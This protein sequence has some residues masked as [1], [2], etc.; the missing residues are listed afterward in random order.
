MKIPFLGDVIIKEGC[1]GTKMYFIQ[2][3]I[4]DIVM[5]TGEVHIILIV[6]GEHRG[7][8]SKQFFSH[9]NRKVATSLSDGSYFGEICLLTN[10]RWGK[11]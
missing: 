10:T 9:S 1:V 2:E 3:G 4:V 5:G 11:S 7:T 8:F 6:I